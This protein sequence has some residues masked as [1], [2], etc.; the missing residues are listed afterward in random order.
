MGLQRT[1]SDIGYV[2]GPVLA[3]VV[4]DLSGYGNA[5]GI[6]ATLVIIALVTIVFLFA[7]AGSSAGRPA[8][9]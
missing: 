3:G 2:A 7:S 6:V 1:I 5:G 8:A 9:Q 4:A